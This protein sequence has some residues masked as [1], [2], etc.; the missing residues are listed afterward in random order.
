[1]KA[2]THPT[3]PN[4]NSISPPHMEDLVYAK[5]KICEQLSDDTYNVLKYLSDKD[6]KRIGEYI[7]TSIANIIEYLHVFF[8]I[9]ENYTTQVFSLMRAYQELIV[10]SFWIY[11]IYIKE[12]QKAEK[13]AERFFYFRDLQQLQ[14]LAHLKTVLQKNNDVF[15][16]DLNIDKIE[17]RIGVLKKLVNRSDLMGNKQQAKNWRAHPCFYKKLD[18]VNWEK[19]CR[20][21]SLCAEK[22][23][24]LKSAPYSENL[25]LLT[26][27][28]HW[29]PMQASYID[30]KSAKLLFRR[31][32]N[33]ALG[34]ALD[35]YYLQC[36]IRNLTRPS[37]LIDRARAKLVYFSI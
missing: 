8:R 12:P 23:V 11:S 7:S 5:S 36:K 3:K 21:A 9:G 29:D 34:F 4:I 14:Q 25:Q 1:M 33:I 15:Y 17:E 30:D 13:L 19:R 16:R 32:M 31:S 37:N 2:I 27:F 18:E 22:V 35:I 28:I 20:A 10:D 24:N 26:S 6:L